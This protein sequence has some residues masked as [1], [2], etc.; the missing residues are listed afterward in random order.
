MPISSDSSSAPPK[1]GARAQ[2]NMNTAMLL[3][4]I[5]RLLSATK[6]IEDE[7][8]AEANKLRASLERASSDDEIIEQIKNVER[9]LMLHPTLLSDTIKLS[10]SA[11]IQAAKS[12]QNLTKKDEALALELNTLISAP[13]DTSIVSLQSKIKSLFFIYHGAVKNLQKAQPSNSD[14]S[15]ACEKV[16]QKICEDLQRL[17]NE[18]DFNGGYGSN[19]KKIRQRLIVGIER[20]ELVEICI[21]VI[22]NIIEGAREERL[23]AKTFLNSVVEELN[24]ISFKFDNSMSDNNDI[25]NKQID[26]L[27]SL[28]ER[29]DIL[30]LDIS[31][32]NNIEQTRQNVQQSLEVISATVDQNEKLLQEKIRLE[33]QLSAIQAQLTS[34]KKETLMHTQRLEAQQ[35]KLYLDTLTQVYNRS[36]LDERFKLEFKRWQRYQNN[37]VMAIV[38]IDHF[39][40][41]NDTFGHIAG[42]KA[43]KIVARA[44]QKTIKDTDFIARFGGEEFVILLPELDEAAMINPLERLRNAIKAIPFRFKGQQ[45]TITIS[46]GATRFA[47]SDQDVTDAFERADSALYEAKSSGRDKV[48]IKL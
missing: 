19:L 39:K 12:L 45:V 41:I 42:D 4:F 32:S 25:N 46:I 33:E 10:N 21:Q 36:A 29:I 43:L 20:H 7:F 35:H 34:L 2:Q 9:Q 11:T 8:S 13:P 5:S 1:E 23:A 22:N 28:R 37:L 27:A 14:D 24:N 3:S 40:S 16:H 17:I 47:E 48:V 31:T 44:L 30:D 6:G 38:D 26:I 18:L 15:V